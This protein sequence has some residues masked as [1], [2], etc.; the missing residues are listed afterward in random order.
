MIIRISGLPG[1]GKSTLG[2]SLSEAIGY[3]LF[4]IDYY[5]NEYKDE[6]KALTHL[7]TDIMDHKDNFILDSAG[8]N[9]RVLWVFQFLKVRV[10]DIKLICDKE[11]LMERL[12][13]KEL[14]EDEYYPY[15]ETRKQ[16]IEDY[17]ED[18]THKE[19]DITIDTTYLTDESMLRCALSNLNFYKEVL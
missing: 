17:F 9:R 2:T 10:V 15:L 6:F 14:P 13:Q 3:K 4:K 19:V 8:F 11:V 12:K 18:M 16:Y 7:F 5:R 1:S